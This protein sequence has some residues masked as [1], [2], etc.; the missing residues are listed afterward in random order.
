MLITIIIR[1][2]S[3]FRLDRLIALTWVPAGTHDDRS[4][5]SVFYRYPDGS[6]YYRHKNGNITFRPPEVPHEQAKGA[7]PAATLRPAVAY[8]DIS[9]PWYDWPPQLSLSV[10][11]DGTSV[12][13]REPTGLA[14]TFE[15]ALPAPGVDPIPVYD[16]SVPLL[17]GGY[18]PEYEMPG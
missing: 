17:H 14:V 5:G 6:E 13:I 8:R 2:C 18:Q 4:D 16:R 9:R 11:T 3:R 10:K 15:P 1:A 7:D 12:I